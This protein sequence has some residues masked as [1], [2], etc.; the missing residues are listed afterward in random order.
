MTE[1]TRPA[2]PE[3]RRLIAVP[4]HAGIFRKGSRYQVRSRHHGRQVCKSFRTLSEAVRFKA[5]VDSGDTQP[6]AREPFNRYATR[7][8]DTYSGRTARGV[9]EGTR[10]SYRDALTRQAIPFF[11]TVRLDKIDPP[12]LREYIG[13]LAGKGLAVRR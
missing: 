5:R 13:H 8:L 4:R 7:W 12:M 1:I 11:G 2:T 3:H 9:S 6:T 10:E